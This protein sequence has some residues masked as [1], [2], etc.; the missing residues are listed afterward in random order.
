MNPDLKALRRYVFLA[1]AGSILVAVFGLFSLCTLLEPPWTG[2]AREMGTSR[3]NSAVPLTI[4]IL[5]VGFG[6]WAHWYA[7]SW[8]RRMVWVYGHV[9]PMEM[10]LSLEMEGGSDDT[11]YYA[12]LTEPGR[13]PGEGVHWRVMLWFGPSSADMLLKQ[14]QVKAR[15][16]MDPELARPAVIETSFGTLWTM[17]GS[18]AAQRL[19]GPAVFKAIGFLE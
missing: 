17:G 3:K 1:K 2:L 6:I 19:D 13:P 12:H 18:G 9:S 8:K 7:G 10:A 4:G 16:F 14:G 5:F 15:V 11:T